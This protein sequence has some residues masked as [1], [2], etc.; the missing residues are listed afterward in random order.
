MF[1]M[2]LR[3]HSQPPIIHNIPHIPIHPIIHIHLRHPHQFRHLSLKPIIIQLIPHHTNIIFLHPITQT[4]L[5]PI[6]HLT[7]SISTYRVLIPP[8]SYT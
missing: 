8:F 7:P 4:I 1:S 5:H 3:N 2:F 6:H